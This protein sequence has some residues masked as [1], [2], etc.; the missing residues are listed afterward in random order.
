MLGRIC[1]RIVQFFLERK[2]LFYSL[3]IIFVGLSINGIRRIQLNANIY[4]I[5]PSGKDYAE[6]AAIMSENS[7]TRQVVFSIR[8]QDSP[9]ESVALMETIVEKLQVSPQRFSDF[10]LQRDVDQLALVNYLQRSSIIE[11]TEADYEAI[12][13][14]WSQADTIYKQLEYVKRELGGTKGLF[15]ANYFS[16]D[17]LAITGD[18]LKKV[19][20]QAQSSNYTVEDGLVY[21]A[22]K[23]RVFFFANLNCAQGDDKCASHANTLLMSVQDD[24]NKRYKNADFESFGTFQI[25][26]ANEQQVRQDTTLTVC[27]SVGLILL[28]LFFFYRKASIPIVFMIPC[29]FGVL[30]GLG[31][32]GYY[33][34][35]IN[36][37]SIA[38]ASVLL[39]IVLDYSFHFFTHLRHSKSIID[40]VKDISFPMLVG[41]FTTVGAF[42][43][44]LFTSS[45]ILQN[46]GLI[47]LV[48]LLGAAI[49]TLIGLPVILS[50]I[51]FQ[52]AEKDTYKIPFPL[53]IPK[54]V[55]SI[56]VIGSIFFIWRNDSMRF[57]GD[58]NNLAYHPSH[59]QEREKTYTGVDPTQ[60]KKIYLFAKGDRL[61]KAQDVNLDLY[62]WLGN[63]QDEFKISETVSVAPYSIS[64]ERW[65]EKEKQWFEFWRHNSGI[66]SQ[67]NSQASQLGFSE[68]AF[69]PF[70]DWIYEEQDIQSDGQELIQQ[71]GLGNLTHQ[72]KDQS[73]VLSILVVDKSKLAEFKQELKS[74]FGDSIFVMDIADLSSQFL[75]SLKDDFNY[76]LFFSSALV[77]LSLLLIYGRIELSVFAFL[78]MA[79]SWL[80]IIGCGAIFGM[81]F[82]FVNIIIVT[83]IFGLGDDFS[84][85]VTDGL[86]TK[87]RYGTD[88]LSSYKTAIILS[89]I[90]TIIGTGVL[91]FAKHPAIQSV[92]GL[93][94]LGIGLVM[95]ITLVVQPYLYNLFVSKRMKKN[96]GPITFFY[97]LQSLFLFGLFFIFCILCTSLL[98]LLLLIPI[99]KDKR[100]YVLNYAICLTARS[101]ISVAPGTRAKRLNESL[102]NKRE[103]KILVANH[104]SFLDIVAMLSIT[105]KMVILVKEWVYRSPIF[106]PCIRF[107]GYL[108]VGDGTEKNTELVRKKIDQGYQVII[109]PEGTRSVDGKITRFHKGAF[110]LAKTLEV[111]I[112]P[113]LLVGL[114][115]VN[116]KND[117]LINPGEF[118]IKFLPTVEPA[119][120]E[121]YQ[122]L[123]KHC[124]MQMRNALKTSLINETTPKFWKA[125]LL[126]NYV[127]K[128]PILEWYVRVK[129]RL[130]SKNFMDYNQLIGERKR[131]YDL[132]C[133]LGYL[134][135]LLHYAN[136]ERLITAIDM[137]QEK[138]QTAQHGIYNKEHL[139][140]ICADVVNY[141]YQ[142]ADVFLL[143]DILH[144]LPKEVQSRLM[145]KIVQQLRPEGLI[146]LRDGLSD[147]S[148]SKRTRW[149]EIWSTKIIG[150]NTVANEMSFL[151]QEELMTFANEN[152]LKLEVKSHSQYTSNQLFVFTKGE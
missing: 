25:A 127:L 98:I 71:L 37:I 43:S 27:I 83:F 52:F 108:Y 65:D 78:P 2:L 34:P 20:D 16:Q 131:I 7:F 32:V 19:A 23:D 133:G 137:D 48:T 100:Q 96:R 8:T 1:A 140:F 145:D 84:I 149:T 61:E 103:G 46:F 70:E 99:A 30:F 111:A 106:G 117:I 40:T 38:T 24:I 18:R 72:G 150:F 94:I 10:S 12:H 119:D 49:F 128:G 41:S 132:G 81:E 21:S 105:P 69:G 80:W 33:H 112:Q 147:H 42:A 97:L 22:N 116:P 90:T 124:Q 118:Y 75:L 55:T 45:T 63:H 35:T 104:A 95:I 47:A 120:F 17:P 79:L 64:Q 148:K 136:D 92:G 125:A 109:F 85:F 44:L 50:S 77:F 146:I 134:D 122:E 93:S 13:A 91:V 68:F 138:I 130:E 28:V 141:D 135:F 151:S 66:V 36:A 152:G 89:G 107:A 126:R 86:M 4:D 113:V 73:T 62:H 51:R 123:T 6:F 142:Q 110:H 29:F 56:I 11:L 121:T 15:Y 102:F 58:L 139:E 57:D 74:T 101:L 88:Q 39:G 14:K 5:F 129:Y 59:L 67:L 54:L 26:V 60:Q 143:N 3:L 76:L 144:Y 82:N 9:E 87:S 114:N 31:F 53:W 115:W